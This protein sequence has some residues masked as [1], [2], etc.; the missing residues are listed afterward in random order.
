MYTAKESHAYSLRNMCIIKLTDTYFFEQLLIN[1]ANYDII[2]D[3]SPGQDD[4]GWNLFLFI[5]VLLLFLV[6][7]QT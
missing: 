6:K 2:S 7:A 1:P 4:L 5:F 3:V